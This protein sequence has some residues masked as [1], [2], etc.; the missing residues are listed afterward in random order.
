MDPVETQAGGPDYKEQYV[1]R[2]SYQ[3]Q[4]GGGGSGRNVG[5]GRRGGFGNG[6]GGRSGG[7]GGPYQDGRNQYNEQPG[8]YYPRNYHGGRGRGGRG[9]GNG[10]NGGGYAY[11]NNA[12]GVEVAES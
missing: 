11:S 3:N 1:P 2:R 10:G 9:S 12:S 4:R 6:R 7:R 5:G 8:N